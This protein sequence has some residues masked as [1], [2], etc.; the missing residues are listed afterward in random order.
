[1]RLVLCSSV[2][3]LLMAS[4]GMGLARA[5]ELNHRHGP[6]HVLELHDKLE[7]TPDQLAAVRASFQ[8]MEA[9]KPPGAELVRCDQPHRVVR[10]KC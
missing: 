4:H 7:L 6:A 10:A 8:R 3:A 5:G 9:A 2:A 1:M